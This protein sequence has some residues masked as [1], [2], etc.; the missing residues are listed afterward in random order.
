MSL[1]VCFAALMLSRHRGIICAL[2]G[3]GVL[4][5]S[6]RWDPPFCPFCAF[7]HDNLSPCQQANILR[8]GLG[9]RS[10][11]R[12]PLSTR[13]SHDEGQSSICQVPR[14]SFTESG[15]M[16]HFGDRASRPKASTCISRPRASFAPRRNLRWCE[17]SSRHCSFRTYKRQ[18][19]R[20]RD[21]DTRLAKY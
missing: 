9:G 18:L 3:P 21:D 4:C 2:L 6:H 10:W 17:R 15:Y 13:R 7:W 14:Q 11:S 16:I 5:S 19:G 20:K 1:S 12:K 8:F